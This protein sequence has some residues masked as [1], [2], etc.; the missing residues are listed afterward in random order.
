MPLSRTRAPI[1]GRARGWQREPPKKPHD[2]ASTG[3]GQ[4]AELRLVEMQ[5]P[6][7]ADD[8]TGDAHPAEQRIDS[9]NQQ[10]VSETPGDSRHETTPDDSPDP[11]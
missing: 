2:W 3:D 7:T 11:P 8:I 5:Q 10:K 4:P 1:L 6:G 9:R